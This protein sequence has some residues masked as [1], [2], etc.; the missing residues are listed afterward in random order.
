MLIN[1]VL[2]SSQFRYTSIAIAAKAVT[3]AIT[4]IIGN[5]IEFVATAAPAAAVSCA[6][7][8][9]LSFPKSDIKLPTPVVTLPIIINAGPAAAAIPAVITIV[10]CIEGFKLE[11]ALTAF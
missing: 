4:P 2:T 9:F 7:S 5:T 8:A 10:F 11:K 1:A 3:A 6:T